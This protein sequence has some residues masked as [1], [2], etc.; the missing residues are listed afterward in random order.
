MKIISYLLEGALVHRDFMANSSTI[1]RGESQRM[2]ARP[3]VLHREFNHRHYEVARCPQSRIEPNVR[4]I[5]SS[6]E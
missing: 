4:G 1:V 6:Y 3:G 5:V 2:S